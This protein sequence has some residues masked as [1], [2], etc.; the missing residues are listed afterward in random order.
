MAEKSINMIGITESEQD[1]ITQL[2]AE[3]RS[4]PAGYISRKTINGR[5]RK[6]LQWNEGGHKKSRYLND[7]AAEEIEPLIERRRMLQKELKEL[8]GKS[9][10]QQVQSYGESL[11]TEPPMA[12]RED[13]VDT[14]AFRTNTITG[15]F[16]KQY[17]RPVRNYK[18]REIYD[19]LEG[20]L[21]DDTEKTHDRVF[22]LYGLRRT[23]KTT[24][25][26]QAIAAMSRGD[27][28]RTA[29]MQV[30]SG[31]T[32][33]DINSDMRW[34]ERSGYR[35]VFIDEV[36]L[37]EDFIHGAA[38][39]SDIYAASGMKIVLSGTD[40]LGFI[41]TQ[42]DELYDR[43][44]LLHTTWI[45]YREFSGVLGIDG[46][47]KYIRY[48]G[49][50]SLGGAR[51]N[52]LSTFASLKSTDEYIDSSIARNIQHSLK[53]YQYGDHFRHLGELYDRGELT[54]AINRVVEDINHRFT[55]SVLADDFISHDLGISAR[56]LRKDRNKPTDVLDRIDKD[57]FTEGLRKK[58]EILN[59]PDRE[60]DITDAHR[61]E[62]KEYLDL[63]DLTV[64]IPTEFL[65]VSNKRLMRT[66]IA[67][68]GMRFAQAEA[69][70]RQLLLDEEFQDLSA[71]DRADVLDRILDE[72]C[73]RMMEEI[74]LLETKNALPDKHAF[75]LQFAVGEF[76]MVVVD[77][78]SVTC[79][80]FEIKHSAEAVPAQYRFLA[81]EELCRQT[82]HR[83]GKIMNK[84]VI[85]RGEDRRDG[86]ISYR[87]VEHY[88][89]LL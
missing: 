3:I 83:Y 63:L 49:T 9:G 57:S 67:Q 81:D 32:L 5:L 71:A 36:T 76:D 19:Q 74:V 10:L 12:V 11:Q 42:S 82:E 25:I 85:Y 43:A 33:A 37:A 73:G 41:F 48:G 87:N 69:L 27:F 21:R 31:T 22:I 26:R 54:S 51:Y 55:L 34:L 62:I 60:I 8:K 39:L 24:L 52:E 65:P 77:P 89:Q 7:S 38:L 72:I 35:Y 58:L 78:I 13:L 59:R 16:L 18:R 44:I 80:I 6:Y 70:V 84:T 15:D 45:P 40:S 68:P 56:N 2:E 47:D 88:L 46:I 61:T 1:R 29:V 30:R 86:E 28:A 64:D 66:V 75:R 4:L 50:M 20:Y 14:Y 53:Y 79:E 23:G 17:T